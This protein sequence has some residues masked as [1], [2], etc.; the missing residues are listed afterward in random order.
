MSGNVYFAAGFYDD[1]T[2]PKYEKTFGLVKPS[3]ENALPYLTHDPKGLWLTSH[4]ANLFQL[5]E[6]GKKAIMVDCRNLDVGQASVVV[7]TEEQAEE[8]RKAIEANHFFDR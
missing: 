4:H 3:G 5:S 1:P 8:L 7:L 6:D 2:K